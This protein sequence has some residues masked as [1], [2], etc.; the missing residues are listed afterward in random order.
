MEQP[1]LSF[2]KELSGDDADFEKSMLDIIKIE[3]PEE[4]QLFKHNFQ[5]KNY[6][7]ASYNVHK[8]KHKIGLLGMQEGAAT[9]S[10]FELALKMGNTKLHAVFLKVIDKIHVYL[11]K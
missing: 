9:A 7:E 11:F 1:N 4:V 5:L 3:F 6:V 8:I 10:E 2:I